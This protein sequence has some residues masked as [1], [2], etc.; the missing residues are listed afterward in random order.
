MT[1]YDMTEAAQVLYN[2]LESGDIDE[3][4]FADTLEAI[5]A[6]DKINSYCQILRQLQADADALKAERDRLELKRRIVENSITIMK[7]TLLGYVQ[8]VGGRARTQ[9]F[10]VTTRKTTRTVI[11][12]ADSIPEQYRTPQPDKISLTDIGRA[13]KAGE[14]VPGAELE[15]TISVT[16]K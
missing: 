10:T 2:M 12:N 1:L 16:I 8:S 13:L 11:R 7:A 9:L 14:T 6:G 5:G 4:T 3:Q 15:E